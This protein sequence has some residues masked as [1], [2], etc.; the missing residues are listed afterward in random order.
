MSAAPQLWFR[1]KLYGYGWMPAS[2][3]GWTVLAIYLCGVISLSI[4]MADSLLTLWQV[5]AIALLFI[6][7]TTLLLII[8]VLT[9]ERARWRWGK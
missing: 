6:T 2:W 7:Q 4:F 3:Q 9:G 8:C 1:A 5:L